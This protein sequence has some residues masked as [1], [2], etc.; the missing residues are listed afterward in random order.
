MARSNTAPAA[1][2]FDQL[3]LAIYRGVTEDTPWQTFLPLLRAQL[4][5][6]VASLVLRPPATG[7]QGLI[8]NCVRPQQSGDE[9]LTLQL[10]DPNDWETI[11]YKEQFFALDPFVNLPQGAVFTLDQ[12]LPR[13]ALEQSEY[14]VAYLKPAGVFHIMGADTT[15]EDGT[16]ARLRI[17]RG[18]DEANFNDA[19]RA[20][21]GRL[22]P[23]L[24]Q[25]I[26]LHA[27]LTRIESERA[28]YATTIDKLAMG[29]ILLD[30]NGLVVSTNPIAQDILACNDALRIEDGQL[31]ADD[32]CGRQLQQ[33]IQ[34]AID[35]RSRGQPGMA[36]ALRIEYGE[37]LGLGLVIRPVPTSAW[38]EGQSGPAVAIFL[39]DPTREQTTSHTTIIELFNLSNAEAA[40]ALLLAKGLTL[41]E[42][43]DELH[44]SQHTA[45]AQLKAIFAKTQVSR[46][47]E[48]I[49]L[50]IKSVATLA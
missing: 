38:A 7:D 43:S 12:L 16:H 17:S 5:A 40:L 45:R 14:Y 26:A 19:E 29:T 31:R 4:D 32:E 15:T 23:H 21:C 9:K 33:L 49:R 28:L 35:S 8:L 3:V 22:I 25:A 42:A 36:R 24:T 6:R 37:G 47:A 44:I 50:I 1:D 11:A 30:E 34:D 46:Q 41:A 39:S 27:R 13:E 48:L 18:A 10:A 2:P 20:L